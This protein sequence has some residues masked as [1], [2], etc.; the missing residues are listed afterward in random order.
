MFCIIAPLDAS[1]IEFRIGNPVVAFFATSSRVVLEEFEI[2]LTKRTLAFKDIILFPVARILTRAF[3][4]VGILAVPDNNIHL[5]EV[6]AA[7]CWSTT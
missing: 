1:E 7:A 6:S 4:A 3:H 2:R 5:T